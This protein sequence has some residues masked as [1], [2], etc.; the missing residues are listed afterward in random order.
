ML[1]SPKFVRFVRGFDA[2]KSDAAFKE[3]ASEAFH[4]LADSLGAEYESMGDDFIVDAQDELLRL[5]IKGSQILA[6]RQGP[7]RQI[8]VATPMSGSLKFEYDTDAEKWVDQKQ[9][10]N[11]LFKCMHDEVIRILR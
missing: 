2:F 5:Y 10:D 6:S 7:L 11:D 3:K 8:W 4:E 9:P 1:S